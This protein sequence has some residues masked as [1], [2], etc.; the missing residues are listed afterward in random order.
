MVEA[1]LRQGSP[2]LTNKFWRLKMAGGRQ[3]TVVTVVAPGL[4]KY[5]LIQ[6]KGVC[7]QPLGLLAKLIAAFKMK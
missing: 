7:F 6:G 2:C 5:S 1:G 3:A 4:T